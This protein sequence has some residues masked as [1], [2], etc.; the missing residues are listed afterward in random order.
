MKLTL[1]IL[2]AITAFMVTMSAKARTAIL[3]INVTTD[4]LYTVYLP[5]DRDASNILKTKDGVECITLIKHR[6]FIR[7]LCNKNNRRLVYFEER[8][9]ELRTT[10]MTPEILIEI[11]GIKEI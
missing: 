11:K 8:S 10:I 5:T 4:R 7:M 3:E 1:Y 6:Q 9:P 2:L